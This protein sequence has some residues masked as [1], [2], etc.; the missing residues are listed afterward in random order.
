MRTQLFV[1]AV[2]IAEDDEAREAG[3]NEAVDHGGPFGPKAGA[4]SAMPTD[5]ET[6]PETA[7]PRDWHISPGARGRRTDTAYAL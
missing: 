1:G 3:A 6:F 2:G 4:G 7:T 5:V